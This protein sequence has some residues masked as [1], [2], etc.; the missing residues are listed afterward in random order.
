MISLQVHKKFACAISERIANDFLSKKSRLSIVGKTVTYQGF[1]NNHLITKTDC[2]IVGQ[3][4]HI[5]FSQLNQFAKECK[6]TE[7]NVDIKG[8]WTKCEE[9]PCENLIALLINHHLREQD[10]VYDVAIIPQKE[11]FEFFFQQKSEQPTRC[12]TTYQ[13]LYHHAF[14]DLQEVLQGEYAI[15]HANAEKPV[16]ASWHYSHCVGFVGF[17]E[18]HKIGVMAHIDESAYNCKYKIKGQSISFF[19]KVKDIV[20]SLSTSTTQL[21]LV[22]MQFILVGGSNKDR[23]EDIQRDA[24]KINDDSFKFTFLK[25]ISDHIDPAPLDIDSWWTS[26]VRLNRSAA[27]DTRKGSFDKCL[28]SYEP[29]L[30]PESSLYKRT[31]TN[32]EANEFSNQRSWNQ[33]LKSAYESIPPI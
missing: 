4:L 8:V 19:Q 15:T 12:P 16:L 18:L 17:S 29:K 5:S 23:L 10:A 27:L 31:N 33:R 3:V 30:N 13:P 28:K 9:S 11:H 7:Q 20:S 24:E 26:S 2:L 22:E 25:S 32:Q 21:S 14:N 1:A 6:Y